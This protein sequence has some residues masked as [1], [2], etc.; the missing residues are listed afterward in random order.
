MRVAG[1]EYLAERCERCGDCLVFCPVMHLSPRRARRE[2]EKLRAGERSVVLTRCTTCLDCE[3]VCRKGCAPGALIQA[4]FDETV[5]ERG[6]PETARYFLPH[7]RP[8]FRTFVMERASA[9]EKALVEKFADMTPAEEVC[10]PGCNM[11]VTPL[12]T[13]SKALEGLDI[14]GTLDACCGEMYFRMGLFDQLRAVAAKTQAYFDALGAKKVTILCTAGYYLFTRVLPEFGAQYSFEME[15][16]LALLKRRLD[17][18]E[19]EFT[20]PLNMRV[21]IQDSCYGKQFG[22]EYMD[23]PRDILT[24]A[25]CEVVEMEQSRECML[26]CF[27]GGFSPYSGYNPVRMTATALRT[28]RVA[29]K[30]GADAV[31]TYCSGCLQ[32]FSSAAPVYRTAL[33]AFHLLELVELALGGS[34]RPFHEEVGLSLLLGIMRNQVPAMLKPGKFAPPG[35]S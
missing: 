3:F 4:R 22:D 5:R 30:S 32:T 7:S 24:R 33:P 28:M 10:Y 25:G 2:I 8:N 9:E 35:I 11:L 18:G 34:P 27:G 1:R 12:L 13:Q 29:K 16:Y 26:C 6:L 17:S 23:M 19:I 14:R 15:P 20:R 31:V 21:T